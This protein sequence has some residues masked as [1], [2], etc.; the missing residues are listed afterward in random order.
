[1]NPH[2]DHRC[3]STRLLLLGFACAVLA[4][5]LL[6]A[7]FLW[8]AHQERVWLESPL[9]FGS[10]AVTVTIERG[11]GGREI[12]QALVDAGVLE[13]RADL[14]R[15][16]RH[17]G[18][19]DRL[20]AGVFHVHPSITPVEL[21]AL[22]Q[23]SA[24]GGIRVTLIEGWTG[25]QMA[26]ALVTAGMCA[27]AEE[28]LAATAAHPRRAEWAPDAET[29]EGFLFPD[30]YLFVPG[31]TIEEVVDELVRAFERAVNLSAYSASAEAQDLTLFEAVT[32][33]SIIEREARTDDERAEMAGVFLNR[34]ELGMRL[35]S[36]A[37]VHFAINDW[38]RALRIADTEVDHPYNTYEIEGLPPGSIC[39][40][41]LPSLMAVVSPEETD[42]LFFVY[43]EALG[44]HRFSRTFAEH[45]RASREARGER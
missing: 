34:L 20:R 42:N 28:F 29:L 43:D 2:V 11:M 19:S 4:L 36:C 8:S 1:M 27:T 24:S 25:Q 9:N 12:G 14:R 16:L 39:N 37:T 23:S 18:G 44:R 13:S 21:V 15:V 41:G 33:A 6:G 10:E 40:P 35:E 31:Q 5:A 22:L 32:L 45:Q 30:T 7:W 26:N 38:S 17:T 3:G